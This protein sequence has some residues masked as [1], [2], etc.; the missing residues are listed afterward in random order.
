M[1]DLWECKSASDTQALDGMFSTLNTL[2]LLHVWGPALCNL[3]GA[4][5]SGSAP[6]CVLMCFG[7]GHYWEITA[8]HLGC[9]GE[10]WFYLK[11]TVDVYFKRKGDCK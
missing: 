7:S 1:P 2:T 10:V 9:F 11:C 3:C 5:K 6:V 8:H 4:G